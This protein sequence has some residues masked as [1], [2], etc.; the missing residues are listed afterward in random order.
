M[1]CSIGWFQKVETT[2]T[3]L[4]VNYMEVKMWQNTSPA[5]RRA[6]GEEAGTTRD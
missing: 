3:G 5:L 4:T 1:P 6:N 2:I